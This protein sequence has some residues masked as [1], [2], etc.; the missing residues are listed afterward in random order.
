MKSIAM[1]NI[2][3][4][5]IIALV[6]ILIVAAVAY[7]FYKKGASKTVIATP[8]KDS[9]NS[10]DPSNNPTAISETDVKDLAFSIHEDLS[11]LNVIGHDLTP[12]QRLLSLSDT[13]F[14]RVYN[15][16][17]SQYQQSDGETLCQAIN[18]DV[19]NIWFQAWSSLVTSM[20]E[21]F[22]K[23]NLI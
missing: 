3:S 8:V 7:Y 22:S 21:R 2:K 11:G 5:L 10:N 14:V 15:S 23:L 4:T 16:Y 1:G 20:N 9:P 18:N 12:Y 6:V 17:N 13:D 19:V